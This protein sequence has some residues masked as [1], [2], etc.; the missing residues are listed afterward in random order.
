MHV[1]KQMQTHCDEQ[2][3]K[4]Q[5]LYTWCT[6][7]QTWTYMYDGY[8]FLLVLCIL[9]TCICTCTLKLTMCYD[10]MTHVQYIVR[11]V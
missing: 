6:D 4:M 3:F 2:M 9:H 11:H 5:M 10:T 8:Q 1:Q 7:V